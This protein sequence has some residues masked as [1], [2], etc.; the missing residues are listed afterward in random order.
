MGGLIDARPSKVKGGAWWTLASSLSLMLLAG[1]IYGFGAWSPAL[2]DAYSMDQDTLDLLAVASHIGNYVVLDS[3]MLTA[4]FGT[5]FGMCLGCAYACIGYSFL[6]FSLSIVPG[7]VPTALL[8]AACWL[9]GHGCGTIDNAVMTQAL[10]DFKDYRGYATGC[11]KA[12]FGL[13]TATVSIIYEAVFRPDKSNFLLFLG[14]YSAVAGVSLVPVVAKTKGLVDEASRTVERKFRILA[15]GL[16]SF[17]IYFFVIQILRDMIS[18]TGWMMIL[19][20][21]GVGMASLFLLPIRKRRRSINDDTSEEDVEKWSDISRLT[22]QAASVAANPPREVTGLQMLT[23]VDFWM[24]MFVCVIAQGC[25]L[26]LLSNAAQILP[27]LSGKEMDSVQTPFVAAI[28]VFNSLA[29]LCFGM[30]SE[31]LRG[32]VPRS[33]F[34][35]A[36]VCFI[37]IGFAVLRL[38][39]EAM[40]WW[41]ALLIGFGY[42]GLWGVQPAMVSELFG[43][44]DFSFK[45]SCSAAAAA[46]GSLIFNEGFAGPIFEKNVKDR[47]EFPNCY[48]RSCFDQTFVV[49]ASCGIPA[50]IVAVMLAI[51]THWVYAAPPPEENESASD[52]E[53]EAT[54]DSNES[55]DHE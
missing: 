34:L 20:S 16:M 47:P 26:A 9:F 28:A 7:Q 15:F 10:A 2:R 14:I 38:G 30:L 11:I 29:R 31:L 55:T 27:A 43:L 13:A 21:V 5:V 40:V 36:A 3:G 17:A 12:Y 4:K 19:V 51:K 6:W 50:I 44:S 23:Y 25:G 49:A 54:T 48:D 42:G 37:T 22:A 41:G 53:D 52:E 1:T 8:V 18:S 45:Y 32:K 39:G 35:V 46:V 33:W 24:F